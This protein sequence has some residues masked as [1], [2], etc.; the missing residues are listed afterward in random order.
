MSSWWKRIRKGVETSTS[1]KKE[2]PDGVWHQ[3]SSC[4]KASL[5]T[6][7]KANAYTCPHCNNHEKIDAEDYFNLI[8]D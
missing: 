7:M 8:F 2:A 1:E 5:V 3:C 6:E 4:K